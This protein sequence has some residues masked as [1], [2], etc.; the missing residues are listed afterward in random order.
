MNRYQSFA[1]IEPYLT[2]PGEKLDWPSKDTLESERIQNRPPLW[3]TIGFG[4]RSSGVYMQNHS[5]IRVVVPA[6]LDSISVNAHFTRLLE[7][8]KKKCT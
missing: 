5:L 1:T 2:K 8:V 6:M 7:T 3:L 4:N